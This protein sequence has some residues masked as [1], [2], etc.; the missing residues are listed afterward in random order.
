MR[1]LRLSEGNGVP[2]VTHVVRGKLA[3]ECRE[4]DSSTGVLT[5]R[6][7]LLQSA[8]STQPGRGRCSG[9]AIPGN[10]EACHAFVM[11]VPVEEMRPCGF[12]GGRCELLAKERN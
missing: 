2:R 1:K 11:L 4:S 7:Q 12:L 6:C 5:Y 9:Q 8:A 10:S 3:F